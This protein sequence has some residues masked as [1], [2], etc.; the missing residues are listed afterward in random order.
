MIFLKRI[1]TKFYHMHDDQ[2][3]GFSWWAIRLIQV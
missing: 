2:R 1:T 3:S